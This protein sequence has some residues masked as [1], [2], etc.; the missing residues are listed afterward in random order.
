MSKILQIL[1]KFTE[2]DSMLGAFFP[3]LLIAFK[4]L[5][6]DRLDW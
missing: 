3:I 5:I 4:I 6:S 2:Q 1:K